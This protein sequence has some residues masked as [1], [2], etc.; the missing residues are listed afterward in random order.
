MRAKAH[1]RLIAL[2]AAVL[3]ALS[4]CGGTTEQTTGSGGQSSSAAAAPA[5]RTVQTPKGPVEVPGDPKKIV[6]IDFQIPYILLDLKANL[7]GAIDLTA[8]KD[9]EPF[10]QLTIIGTDTGELNFDKIAELDPDLILA[11][12]YQEPE[13]EKLKDRYPTVLIPAAGDTPGWK[14]Q[15]KAVAEAVGKSGAVDELEK[16]YQAR[17][18]EIKD[19]HKDKI[20][21]GKWA[22]LGT[23]DGSGWYLYDKVGGP[24]TAL[25]DLGIAF[26]EATTKVADGNVAQYSIEQLNQLNGATVLLFDDLGPPV[27][28]PGAGAK[29]KADPLFTSITAVKAGKVFDGE[30]N[31]LDY[32]DA[33]R[34]LD[35]VDAV[36]G[37]L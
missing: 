9:G 14:P 32:G 23:Y 30:Y 8:A 21:A 19:K 28:A 12:D 26:D 25:A 2:G 1:S 27:T 16:K 4:A 10:K 24:S 35:Q 7:A 3:L 20:A 29:L 31:I 11:A 15:V 5:K 18:T 13:Y 6:A 17:V 22:T 37:K 34:V 33:L 36:L